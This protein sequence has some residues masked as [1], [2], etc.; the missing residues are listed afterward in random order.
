M[1]RINR[2]EESFE[3]RASWMENIFFIVLHSVRLFGLLR[4]V[5]YLNIFFYI[6]SREAFQFGILF[7]DR[8]RSL[9]KNSLSALYRRR[10]RMNRSEI[11]F[12]Q[13]FSLLTIILSLIGS[14]KRAWHR[15]QWNYTN[16]SRAKDWES[17]KIC[18]ERNSRRFTRERR[19][20]RQRLFC[21][22]KLDYY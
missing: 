10:R 11:I 19:W 6:V 18:C 3:L 8:H 2:R 9:E 5:L 15:R 14:V 1:D 13:F 21:L 16:F 4:A 17:V 7:S 22:N 12:I 20:R